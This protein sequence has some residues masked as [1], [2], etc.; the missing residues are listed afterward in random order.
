[1]KGNIIM[2]DNVSFA[3]V[4]YFKLLRKGPQTIYKLIVTDPYD[5]HNIKL[6]KQGD[7]YIVTNRHFTDYELSRKCQRLIEFDPFEC[8][9]LRCEKNQIMQRV[10]ELIKRIHEDTAMLHLAH[11]ANIESYDEDEVYV[12]NDDFYRWA[13]KDT[14]NTPM[15]DPKYKELLLKE[16]NDNRKYL[17]GLNHKRDWQDIPHSVAFGRFY[18]QNYVLIDEMAGAPAPTEYYHRR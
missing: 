4:K 5:E 17:A 1:M 18:G 15:N 14:I 10:N 8:Y 7:K 11:Q 9:V 12:L 16:E 3:H 6:V 13:I 2:I